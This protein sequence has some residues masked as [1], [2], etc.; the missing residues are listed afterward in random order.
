LSQK[1]AGLIG[2]RLTVRSDY[3]HGSTFKLSMQEA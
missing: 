1:L 3:G 2:G